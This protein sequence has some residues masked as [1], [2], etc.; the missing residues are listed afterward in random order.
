M[1]HSIAGKTALVTGA[2]SGIGQ[3]IALALAAQSMRLVITDISPD[4]LTE[5]TRLLAGTRH[6]AEKLDVRDRSAWAN[7]LDHA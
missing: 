2:A 1:L 6:L 3:A 7:L 4:R 5:T